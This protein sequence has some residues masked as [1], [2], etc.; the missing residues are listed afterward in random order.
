MR[1]RKPLIVGI[2]IVKFSAKLI[3]NI[4]RKNQE[5]KYKNY[6]FGPDKKSLNK[7]FAHLFS[8][9]IRLL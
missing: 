4:M 5:M 8:N 6:L 9:W 2:N 3:K 1:R 7:S